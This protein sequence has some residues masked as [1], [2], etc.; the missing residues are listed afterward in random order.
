M[1]AWAFAVEVLGHR[2]PIFAPLSAMVALGMGYGRR[3]R[4]ATE[5][6]IGVALGILVADLAV[7]GIG[8][9]IWQIGLVSLVAMTIAVALGAGHMVVLQA[10]ISAM[11]V[12]T[13]QPPGSGQG[14]AR[15][16][17]AL[18]GGAMALAVMA[19]LATDPLRPI[20][21]A[22]D[23]VLDEL[24]E[25][26]EDIAVALETR[27]LE[28]AKRA[29]LRARAMEPH[30]ASWHQAVEAGR[31]IVRTAPPQRHARDQLA[32]YA[33]AV[34]AIDLAVRNVRVLA[35]GAMRALELDE[36]VPPEVCAALRH[37]AGAV[38]ELGS[39]LE[40]RG[41]P[42]AARALA[43]QAAAEATAAHE[44]SPSLSVGVL[45]GQIRSTATDILRGLGEEPSDARAAV[46]AA[47][48][49]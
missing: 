21:R 37:L 19:V 41:E 36:P 42:G 47:E 5:L 44:H 49:S 6:V 8:T 33:H 12:V 28:T 7:T 10:G 31:E 1:A 48:L 35:R 38:R 40:N 4:S 26:L 43:L 22:A 20:K 15:F 39:D 13:V 17:D 27:D 11:L 16:L 23:S 3:L 2:T 18:A 24:A 32:V 29:L 34:A 30:E 45:A 9:G 14:T 46:R 25:V